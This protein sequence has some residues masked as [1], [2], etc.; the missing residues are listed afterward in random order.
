MKIRKLLCMTMSALMLATL[1]ACSTPSDTTVTTTAANGSSEATETTDAAPTPGETTPEATVP[2]E[3]DTPIVKDGLTGKDAS[4]IVADM[5]FGFNIGN[6]LDADSGKVTNVLAHEIAWGNPVINQELI[7]GIVAAGFTTIRIPTTWKDFI[8]DDESYTIDPQYLARVKEV[9]DYCYKHD[10]YVILNTHH[11]KWLENSELVSDQEEIAKKL[12][13]VWSQIADYFAAYDQHLIFEGLN[14]PRLKGTDIEWTGNAEAYETL[15]YLSQIFVNAVRGNGKGYNDERCLMITGYAASNSASIMRAMSIPT[16]NGEAVNNLI[17]SVHSYAPYD[18]CLSTNQQ[19][20]DLNNP[21]DTG[22]IDAV[23]SAIK[24]E[25]LDHDIPVVL[26]ETGATGKSNNQA[27]VNW[28]T[29][30]GTKAAEYGVP[31]VLWDNGSKGTGGENHCY[32]NRRTGELVDPDFVQAMIQ[33]KNDTEWGCVLHS[34]TDEKT[35]ASLV[36]GSV[37]F[38]FDDGK[39]STTDWDYTYIQTAASELYF[40]G[41]AIAV[42]Y[43]GTGEPKMVLDS[44]ELN[45]WWMPIDATRIETLGDKKVAYFNIEN[46]TAVIQSF[47]VSKFSQLRNLSFLSA[48]GSITTYEVSVIGENATIIYKVNGSTYHVG[49][50]LPEDPVVSNLEFL[51]WYSTKDYRPGTE[52]TGEQTDE[53]ITVYAK[54]GLAR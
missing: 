9:V 4:E 26:G 10:I 14:E 35:E 51:G 37:I 28:V 2:P 31:I 16:Y 20:F 45:Q 49:T 44:A 29:Y 36:N 15:N 33:A 3:D 42:V 50:E 30:M 1:T 47:G 19:N 46:I 52:Y 23:F 32:F 18:F 43:T 21:T 53:T 41:S 34:D 24:S 54:F 48:N 5:G 40:Y 17:V 12:G 11:E 7:D 6:T 8:S 39:T 38:S 25:F 13:A 22:A 27:R